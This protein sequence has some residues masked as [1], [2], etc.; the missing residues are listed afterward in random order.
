MPKRKI[1]E[2]APRKNFFQKLGKKDLLLPPII[3]GAAVLFGLVF[4]QIVPPPEILSV[5]LKAHSLDSYNVYPRVQ[6]FVDGKQYLLP[7]NVGKQPNE[8]GE[9]CLKPIHTDSVGDTL[10]VQYIRPVQLSLPDLMEIYAYDNK[11]VTL[12][13]NT[14]AGNYVNSTLE[15]SDYDIQYSYYSDKGGFT[16]IVNSSQFPPF[17][18]TFFGKIDFVSKEL[19]K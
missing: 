7:G 18:N 8:K 17:S 19:K 3:I 14:T 13:E 11:T 4:T 12:V 15:L 1:K 16:K 9:E 6:I 2:G 5:C 10:H